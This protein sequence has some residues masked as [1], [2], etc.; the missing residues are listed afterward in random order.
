MDATQFLL[1]VRLVLRPGEPVTEIYSVEDAFAFLLNWPTQKG[2]VFQRA[3]D[4]CLAAA[5][6]TVSSEE[7][8]KAFVRFARVS[9]LLARDASFDF[10]QDDGGARHLAG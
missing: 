6:D 9:G 7:A 2:P 5:V 8:R 1:P 10:V 4:A 3:M